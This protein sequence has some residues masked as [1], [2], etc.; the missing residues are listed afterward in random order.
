[1]LR[2][3]DLCAG[4]GGFTQGLHRTGRVRCVFAN[5]MIAPSKTIFDANRPHESV[6]EMVLGD[7]NKIDPESIP[8]HDILTGGFPC[9][10]FSTAGLRKGFQDSRSQVF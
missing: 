3:V 5:D 1:M 10:A 4:T 8:D 9:Q 6:P 7:L 2:H